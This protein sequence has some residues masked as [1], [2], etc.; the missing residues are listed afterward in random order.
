MALLVLAITA[1]EDGPMF[2]FEP[3]VGKFVW[4][5]QAPYDGEFRAENIEIAALVQLTQSGSPA[6]LVDA[7]FKG[8]LTV[9]TAPAVIDGDFQTS[10]GLWLLSPVA[11]DVRMVADG[12]L[13]YPWGAMFSPDGERMVYAATEECPSTPG[14]DLNAGMQLLD[15]GTMES[16]TLYEGERAPVLR[17]WAA[18][19]IILAM[20]DVPDLGWTYR[21]IG[22]EPR[23]ER[24]L[25]MVLEY[26]GFKLFTDIPSPLGDQVLLVD[27]YPSGSSW[28][29][30]FS[31]HSLI[32]GEP[33]GEPWEAWFTPQAGKLWSPNGRLLSYLV[34]GSIQDGLPVDVMMLNPET[35]EHA[36]ILSG[37][38]T[39]TDAFLPQ[40]WSPKSE[41]VLLLADD[42]TALHAVNADGSGYG[43]VAGSA[44]GG[45]LP[46]YR[47]VRW[48]AGGG[49]LFFERHGPKPERGVTVTSAESEIWAAVVRLPGEGDD[50]LEER[51]RQLESG[52]WPASLKP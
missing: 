36:A 41:A 43:E 18:P 22:L 11:G 17:G 7:S 24:V 20:R 2:L 12:V 1:C 31:L 40:T 10:C 39:R 34:A 27:E 51:V 23:S 14:H 52:P 38:D 3:P 29:S 47:N 33:I 16:T 48:P 9:S 49:Y 46:T 15:L 13:G 32:T 21:I 30:E 37:L 19:D 45:S 26:L 50:A 4:A 35:G 8:E 6:Y 5:Y 25:D 28:N 42:R 44:L